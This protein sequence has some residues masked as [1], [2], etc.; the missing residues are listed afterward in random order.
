MQH[1]PSRSFPGR[2]QQDAVQ[3][4]FRRV[5]AGFEGSVRRYFRLT[6]VEVCGDGLSLGENECDDGNVND[7]DGCSSSCRVEQGFE[8]RRVENSSDV[9]TDVT[10]SYGTLT[11]LNKN[12]VTARFNK[13]LV[14]KAN[15]IA[16]AST[17]N[18]YMSVSCKLT[19]SLRGDYGEDSVITQLEFA[20]APEC[21]LRN[22]KIHFVLEFKT[23]SLLATLDNKTLATPI[24]ISN[25]IK[26]SNAPESIQASAEA[27]GTFFETS[28]TV[29]LAIVLGAMLFQSVAAESFWSLMNMLQV[30]SYLPLLNLEMPYNLEVFLT[31]YLSMAELTVPLELVPDFS[32]SPLRCMQYFAA[33]AFNDRFALNDYESFNFLYVFFDE[34]FTWALLGL[35]YILL[36]VL[37]SSIRSAK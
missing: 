21:T 20:V 17:L 33:D 12:L 22:T 10:R 15:S 16:L 37:C 6:R 23:L 28:S 7:G 9:C 26:V 18:L 25:S 24:L 19:W 35:L 4:M 32:Y 8:C 13:P 36:R 11:A 29:T 5:Q 2:A 3:T 34:L 30:L 14:V 1:R 31:E 27:V